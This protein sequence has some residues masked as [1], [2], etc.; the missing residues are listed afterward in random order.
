MNYLA[1]LLLADDTDAGR[2]G[3][4]L[5]DFTNVPND[6]LAA[7]YGEALAEGV[8]EHRRLDAFTDSHEA[9][10]AAV[11]L[12][13]PRHRHASRIVID[14]LFDHFLSVHW[15]TYCLVDR[16]AFIGECHATLARVDQNDERLPERFRLFAQRLAGAGMLAAY[17]SLEGVGVALERVSSRT[18]R[19]SSIREALPDIR[20]CYQPLERCFARFFPDACAMARR[21]G[22]TALL[23]PAVDRAGA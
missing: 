22:R 16:A 2:I 23:A 21:R 7:T 1:H 18:P 17:V 15:E 10:L 6:R 19:G 3:S 12:L 8:I 20:A 9:V 13:F 4:L 5:G 11:G 14:I